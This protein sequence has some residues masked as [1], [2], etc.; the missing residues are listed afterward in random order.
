VAERHTLYDPSRRQNSSAAAAN[1]YRWAM[2]PSVA[3]T[4]TPDELLQAALAGGEPQF[5]QLVEPYLR[6][7]HLHC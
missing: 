7:I 3:T 6:E 4:P 5:G 2:A 1:G